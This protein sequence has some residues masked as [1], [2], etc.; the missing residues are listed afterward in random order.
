MNRKEYLAERTR[1][2]ERK[3]SELLGMVAAGTH[4]TMNQLAAAIAAYGLEPVSEA[5]LYIA[6]RMIGAIKTPPGKRKNENRI[7]DASVLILYRIELEDMQIL[8]QTNPRAFKKNYGECS[9]AE[10]ARLAISKKFA[11]G[12]ERIRKLSKRGGD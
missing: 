8:K 11:V 5:A 4:P 10:A 12:V 1:E 6:N 3:W 7:D 9:P 2:G